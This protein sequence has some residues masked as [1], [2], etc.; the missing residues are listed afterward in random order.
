MT[1]K[2]RETRHNTWLVYDDEDGVIHGEFI[3]K[4]AAD[5]LCDFLELQDELW[6]DDD[7]QDT[8]IDWEE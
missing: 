2:V 5:D 4:W 7:E 3:D 1:F 8:L 6:Y